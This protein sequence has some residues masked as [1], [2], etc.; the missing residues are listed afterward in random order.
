[1]IVGS[2][3]AP[4]KNHIV[5]LGNRK[6]FPIVLT[7]YDNYT[8][9][10][11]THWGSCTVS[12]WSIWS[13]F[14]F[15]GNILNMLPCIDVCRGIDEYFKNNMSYLV[16]TL[17]RQRLEYNAPNI[18]CKEQISLQDEPMWLLFRCPWTV[19]RAAFAFELILAL[20]WCLWDRVELFGTSS[21][22]YF[23]PP[24]LF[25]LS[26]FISHSHTL[27]LSSVYS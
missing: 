18:I 14:C 16:L 20:R 24:N 4:Q 7:L 11:L 13:V 23:R 21:Y 17:K 2:Y 6:C 15:H 9:Y 25:L 8:I 1:M 12:C 10:T 26:S 3:F 22:V 27:S 5:K 19:V